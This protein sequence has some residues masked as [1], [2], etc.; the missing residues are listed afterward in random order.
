MF[1]GVNETTFKEMQLNEGVLMK[2]PYVKEQGFQKENILCATRGGA[3]LNV[4]PVVRSR[5]VDGVPANTMEAMTTDYV[6][7]TVSFVTINNTLEMYRRALGSADITDGD[8]KVKLRHGFKTSDFGDLY[9]LGERAD[10]DIIQLA[11][12]NSI[13]NSGLSLRTTQYGEGELSM[14]IQANYSIADLD[15]PPVEIE[16]IKA[17][18]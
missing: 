12:K 7:A 1:R 4:T 11:F 14:T 6:T 10:G 3:T 2:A 17:G 9:W 16:V 18:E 8:T 15:T 5:A 13:N